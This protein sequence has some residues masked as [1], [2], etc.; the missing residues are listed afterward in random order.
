MDK[1]KYSSKYKLIKGLPFNS[2][3]LKHFN[4]KGPHG[5]CLT[6]EGAFEEWTD[7]RMVQKGVDEYQTL[8]E[9][10]VFIYDLDS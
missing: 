4:S 7:Y 1:D 3:L 2:K 5:P 8:T 9:K 6:S 10:I